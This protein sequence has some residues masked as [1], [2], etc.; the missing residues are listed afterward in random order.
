MCSAGYIG[1]LTTYGINPKPHEDEGA[2][3]N[4]CGE[5][6]KYSEI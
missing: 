6:V 5:S 1:E 3:S 2:P 4:Y